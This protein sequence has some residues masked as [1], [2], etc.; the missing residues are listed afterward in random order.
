MSRSSAVGIPF[1][2]STSGTVEEWLTCLP[3]GEIFVQ[4]SHNVAQINPNRGDD[5]QSSFLPS[6]FSTFSWIQRM[7]AMQSA[8][9]RE[10]IA[11]EA[12]FSMGEGRMPQVVTRDPV[13]EPRAIAKAFFSRWSSP[14]ESVSVPASSARGRWRREGRVKRGKR[15][16]EE[17]VKVKADE[18]AVTS[19]E[20]SAALVSLLNSPTRSIL[21]CFRVPGRLVMQVSYEGGMGQ[22][23]RTL[24]RCEKERPPPRAAVSAVRASEPGF[25][26]VGPLSSCRRGPRLA[27]AI[28]IA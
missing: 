19:V 4:I 10:A 11:C 20:V 23:E 2:V 18:I 5:A 6:M 21:R 14:E 26:T 13:V 17:G 27:I 16:D 15:G 8:T 12:A 1:H 22:E 9:P 28:E 25:F 7:S 24:E 3:K